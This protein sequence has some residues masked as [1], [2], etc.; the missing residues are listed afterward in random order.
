[1]KKIIL[2]LLLLSFFVVPVTYADDVG[3]ADGTEYVD[4]LDDEEEEENLAASL[5]ETVGR[6]YIFSVSSHNK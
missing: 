1:M 4:D 2:L 6:C 3:V 5:R